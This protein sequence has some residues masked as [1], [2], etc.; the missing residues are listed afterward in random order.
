MMQSNDWR[1]FAQLK[2]IPQSLNYPETTMVGMVEN[3]AKYYPDYIAYDFMGKRVN[4]K[5]FIIEIE[6]CAKALKAIGVKENDYVTICMPNTPQ[7]IVFLYAIN[8]IGAIAN[9][10]HPLSS[11]KEID[12]FLKFA[13]SE[14]VLTL[15]MFFNKFEDILKKS[16]KTKIIVANIKEE[17]PFLKKILFGIIK[18]S[19]FS[20]KEENKNIV[21]WKHFLENGKSYYKKY[22]VKKGKDDIALILYSGGTTGTNKGVMLSNLNLN[23]LALQILTV[24]HDLTPGDAIVAILPIFHGF[25]LGI[26]VH[27]AVANGGTTFLVPKFSPKAY[28][29]ILKREKPR[30]CSRS[31]N[32]V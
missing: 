5:T 31:S 13:N 12:F 15:D 21:S 3:I 30:I 6:T 11:K 8:M 14:F 27:T 10:I 18:K 28:A 9:I 32:H 19:K 29:D 20:Q 22:R 16:N 23:A 4:Y 1:W 2:D 7:A 25:G 26:C 24:G 17:L